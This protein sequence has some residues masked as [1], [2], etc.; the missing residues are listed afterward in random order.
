MDCVGK[1][2][3]SDLWV[4]FELS[5]LVKLGFKIKLWDNLPFAG[6]FI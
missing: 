6:I 4:Y 2:R 3:S 1:L 5:I